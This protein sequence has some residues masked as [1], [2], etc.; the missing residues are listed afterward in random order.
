MVF[1]AVI[2]TDHLPP[3]ERFGHF[4]DQ[5]LDLPEPVEL[6]SK[7][8]SDFSAEASLRDFGTFSLIR[9]ITTADADFG[10]RRSPRL[11]RK[12]DPEEYRLLISMHGHSGIDQDGQQCL[13]GPGE[14]GF[15][16]TSRPSEGWRASTGGPARLLMAG[17]PHSVL[18][19]PRITA[20]RLVGVKLPADD[21]IA[22]L[23]KSVLTELTNPARPHHASS[24][25]R[26]ANVAC[27]LFA[28]LL[29]GLLDQEEHLSPQVRGQA[30]LV[31]IQQFIERNLSD[32]AL[33]PAAVAAAH[34][35]AP[36]T[37]H[38]L[39]QG[40]GLTVAAWIRQRRLERCRRDLTDPQSAEQPLSAIA[41]R[42]GFADHPH[43]SR[44]FRR[45]YGLTP[46]EYRHLHR[47]GTGKG[48]AD[49]HLQD[50]GAQFQAG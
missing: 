49:T 31:E 8:T 5:A 30:L 18:A 35:I 1:D 44:A 46:S 7:V 14:M 34:S 43:L 10:I 37:L 2:R 48:P 23:L 40:H 24:A 42:W 25:A 11:I 41:A 9:F 29:A 38:R 27:D 15:Y 20:D 6:R 3:G 28:V 36:R 33:S 47:R 26:L 50:E 17:F 16:H 39:F 4:R 13:L 21:S 22:R 12:A 45:A 19:S 32:P